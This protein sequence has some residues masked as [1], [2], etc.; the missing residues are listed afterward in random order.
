MNLHEIALEAIAHGLC[1]FD[2]DLRITLFN[3]QMIDILGLPPDAVRVGL[4]LQS[5]LGRWNGLANLSEQSGEHARLRHSRQFAS[6][7]AFRESWPLNDGRVVRVRYEPIADGGWAATF[8]DI[9]E[10]NRLDVEL[11][12]QIARFGTALESMSHGFAMYSAD[13]RLMVC[14]NQYLTYLGLDSASVPPGTPLRD[15]VGHYY[16]TYLHPTFTVEQLYESVHALFVS[17]SDYVRRL[18]DGRYL[19]TRNRPMPGGGWV[20]ACEDVTEREQVAE[21]LRRQ[22]RLFDAA[23][24][25]MSQGFCMIDA[26]DRVIV[27]NELYATIFGADSTVV[28]PGV[29]LREVFEHGIAV[30]NY[31]GLT[32]E[33]LLRRRRAKQAGGV[34]VTYDYVLGDGRTVRALLSP[35]PDGSSVGTFEDVTGLRQIEAARRTAA[36][37]LHRQ[38]L[39][40]DATLDNMAHGL[41]VFDDDFRLVLCNRQY[42][43]LY[44]LDPETA[45]P[46]TSLLDMVRVSVERG[47]HL[48]GLDAETIVADFQARLID[49]RE[50]GMQRRFADGRMIAI[51]SRPM[52][53]GGWVVTYEDITEQMRAAEELREQHRR[54]DAALNYMPHGLVMLDRNLRLVVCNRRYLEM[55]GLSAE[56]VKPGTT[57]REIVEHGVECGNHHAESVDE[58]L[59]RLNEE[60][61]PGQRVSYRRLV[62]D[63]VFKATYEPMEHGGWVAIHEEITEQERAGEAQREQHRLFDAAL[64]NM[65]HGLAMFDEKLRLLVCNSRYLNLYG[66]SPDVVK[67]GASIREIVEHSIAIGNLPGG[68]P[69]AIVAEYIRKLEAGDYTSYRQ[70]SDGRIIEVIYEVMPHGGWVVMHEDVTLRRHAEQRIEHMAHHDILTDLPNRALFRERMADGLTRA[71]RSGKPMAVICLDL[72]RFKLVNDTLGHPLGDKLLRAVASRLGKAIRPADTIARLGGDEFAILMH[73]TSV[74]AVATLAERLVRIMSS[75]F[76]IDGHKIST[77][78]SIGI[79]MAPSDG[80]TAD[81]LMKCAD[82]ALYRAKAEGRNAYRFFESDMSAQVE[83]RRALE[84][85]LRQALA[86]DEFHLVFQPLVRAE[87]RALT[88]FEALLRWSHPLR[89][90]VSPAQFI[91]IAEETG[92]ILPIGEWVLREACR[93][94]ARWPEPIRVSVNLSPIQFRGH[95]LVAMVRRV[96]AEAGLA[97]SRL[98]LEITEAILLRNDE[99]TIAELHELRAL[100]I[101]IVM[102]DFGIGYSSLSYLRS[103]PF[104]KIKIDRSFIADLDGNK[105][106]VAIIRAVADLGASLAIDTTAEGVETLQQFETIRACGCTEVQGYLISRPCRATEIVSFINDHVAKGGVRDRVDDTPETPLARVIGGF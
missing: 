29:T 67:P 69:D 44:R 42:M 98:E 36:A 31:P 59:A 65:A 78:L 11:K 8:E 57:V 4:S 53:H 37:E 106:N 72:D 55:Y 105:D 54:F 10:Q 21:D 95:S 74:G 22:H 30:G 84:V 73:A 99:A 40:L 41:C 94:A 28:K 101:R 14:N 20:V 50:P 66:M 1:L 103:F 48:P 47:L 46:G 33:D 12:A 83:A 100:G 80:T 58:R 63:R 16:K 85:D 32:V 45:Q 24:N 96:L 79:A 102:D 61:A 5:L 104:D 9:T 19:Y 93:E 71:L 34:P 15:V 64:N 17:G 26:D 88:G 51:R 52:A 60:L 90:S 91:P 76:T 18:G 7:T 23:L 68:D 81:H 43:E 82:L 6:G 49:K 75:P 97:P 77:G 35:M 13:E 86:N 25:G 39:L 87:N 2:T 38:N 89:G 92:L 62:R 56:V 3:R 70:I 27:C